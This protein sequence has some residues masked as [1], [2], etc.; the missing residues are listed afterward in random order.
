MAVNLQV[1]VPKI[2]I[3]MTA[4][5]AAQAHVTGGWAMWRWSLPFKSLSRTRRA[6]A[7]WQLL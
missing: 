5:P 4:G 1:E 7:G 3:E 2:K 6:R